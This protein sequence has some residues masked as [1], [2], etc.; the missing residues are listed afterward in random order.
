MGENLHAPELTSPRNFKLLLRSAVGGALMGLANLV[1]GVSGG[2]MLLAAGVY[3]QFIGG[4][5]EVFTLRFRSATVLMLGCVT[6]AA[7]AAIVGFAGLVSQLVV[8]HQWVMYSLFLGL[9]LGGVPIL[10]RMARP[11][12]SVVVLCALGGI[13][14]MGV[15]ALVEPAASADGGHGAYLLLFVCGL[16]AGSAMILPGVSGSYL[17][18]VLGQYV[19]ILSAI[20][21]ARQAVAARDVAA[22]LD[23][24]QV[25]APVGLGVLAGVVGVSNLVKMLLDKFER[26]TLGV[27]L[28]LL[29]GAGIGLWP[30]VRAVPPQVGSPF[31]GDTVALVDG[32]L[33]MQRSGRPIEARHWPTERFA[34]TAVHIGGAAGLMLAG[35]VIS[36]AI[37]RLGGN[38]A[39]KPQ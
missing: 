3:P 4:V 15:I 11:V 9:T 35:F 8:H 38:G 33:V 25:I 22:L 28:G 29:L 26:P 36:T 12:D 16:L 13:A 5:A 23:T 14:V 6:V 21:A 24:L 27:L 30:F 19:T 1:P 7:A 32:R 37:G 39:P 2:T 18:L 20:S 10:W 31:R 17:L 34:P